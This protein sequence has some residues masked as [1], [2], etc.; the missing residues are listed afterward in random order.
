M[1][2]ENLITLRPALTDDLEVICSFAY[3]EGM[4]DIT[5]PDNVYVAVNQDDEIVGF[6]RLAF[7]DERVCHVNPIVVYPTWRGY[8]VGRALTEFALERYGELRLVSRGGSRA[9]YEAL[10]FEPIDISLIYPSIAAECDECP[11]YEE[12][13][14]CAMHKLPN[15]KRD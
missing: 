14:P 11:L 4:D 10:G 13:Q 3:N 1:S 8:G 12:C 15:T 2:S 6:I 9:F 5:E 7:D